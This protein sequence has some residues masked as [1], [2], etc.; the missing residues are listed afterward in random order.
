L[1]VLLTQDSGDIMVVAAPSSWVLALFV[2]LQLCL[3]PI[4]ALDSF[5][6]RGGPGGGFF[7]DGGG[8]QQQQQQQ[9]RAPAD[10]AYYDLLGISRT[11]DESAIKRAYRRLAVKMHPDKGGDPE[12]FKELGEAYEVLSDGAKR[13]LYDQYGKAGLDGPP[14]PP[15]GSAEDLLSAMFGGRRMPRGPMRARDVVYELEVPLKDMYRGTSRK[16]RIW[17]QDPKKGRI[18]K[19]VDI[20]V[21]RGSRSGTKVVLPGAADSGMEGVL[22]G[23]LVFILKEVDTGEGFSR[24]GDHLVLD[25]ELSLAE[26]LTGFSRNVNLVSGKKMRVEM[27]DGDIISPGSYRR[28]PGGGM[29]CTG[30]PDKLGDLYLRFQVR[31]PSANELH[32]WSAEDRRKLR[33]LLG[34]DQR[35]RDGWRLGAEAKDKGVHAEQPDHS[36]IRIIERR[37]R[38]GQDSEPADASDFF[39]FFGF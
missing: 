10:S 12:K 3:P 21:E 30:H 16:I 17:T 28:I 34:D 13:K 9:Q 5:S 38:E 14:P 27:E 20:E 36:V 18:A 8:P 6:F 31:F 11:A 22:P 33:D 4:L 26:A 23:D 35:S 25:L 2:V 24:V 1:F 7:F 37:E 29:P 32:R 39:R 15:P 19:D